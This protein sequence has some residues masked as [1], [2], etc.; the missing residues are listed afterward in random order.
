MHFWGDNWFKEHGDDLYSAIDEI[1]A[2]LHK[3]H[4]GVCGK[5]KWGCYNDSFLRFWDGGLYDILF[6][7]R[8]YIGSFGHKGLFKIKWFKKFVDNIHRYI[9]FRIDRGTPWKYMS[10]ESTKNMDLEEY[11][12][13]YEKRWWKGLCYYND[14]IG[15]TKLV[16]DHLAEK[17]NMVFQQVCAKYPDIVDELVSDVTCYHLIKPCKWGNIDG[18]EIHNRHWTTLTPPKPK[19]ESDEKNEGTEGARETDP[20]DS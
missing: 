15:L 14:K 9:Y 7:Y 6:G 11:K 2:G 5:E 12:R 20:A 18:T 10:T 1:E 8:A 16:N 3:H 4:I 17:L 13:V 19:E